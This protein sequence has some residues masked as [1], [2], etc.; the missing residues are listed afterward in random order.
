MTEP[1]VVVVGAGILGA[2][3]AYHLARAGRRV[4]V[5]EA[6]VPAAG[7]SAN[8]FA[9]VNA[10][11]K[12]PEPYHRLNAAGVAEY[13]TVMKELGDDSGFRPG[14]SLE[15]VARDARDEL[16]DRVARLASRGYASRFI[17]REEARRIDPGLAIPA[18]AEVALFE[19][20]GW[21]DA[22]RLIATLLARATALGAEVRT[23]TAARALRRDGDRVLA[24]E[25]SR[26]DI[27]AEAVLLCAGVG[28]ASL[29]STL[30]ARVPV[31]AVPG[32]LA[33]TSPVSP[34]LGRVV[35]A[36]GVHLRPDESGGVRIGATDLDVHAPELLAATHDARAG[37]AARR[38]A[39]QP[40]LDRARQVMPALRN[41]DIVTVRIGARPMPDDRHTIAGP[42][43]GVANAWVIATHSAITMGP[44]L[45][46]LI[47]AEMTGAPAHGL[48]AP[49]RPSRFR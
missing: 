8:S 16:R 12:E 42:L 5:L 3:A 30:G 15:W 22:P 25:T 21:V 37:A 20:D 36:P 32:M 35:H 26:G 18:G 9:W 7:A 27:A 49:F 19:P 31:N 46:R 48:L 23:E 1:R 33:V 17:S 28:S 43:P 39:A 29:A 44:L 10:V 38:R 41:A 4:L 14:G 40:L 34:A 2:A 45:G 13:A 6:A 24:I 11:H 47:A